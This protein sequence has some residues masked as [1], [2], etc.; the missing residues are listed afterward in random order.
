MDR[1]AI[2]R[3]WLAG[4][5]VW[6]LCAQVCGG[7]Q[8]IPYEDL[9]ARLTDLERLAGLPAAGEKCVQFSSYDRRSRYDP[10]TKKYVDWPANDDGSGFLNYE[11]RRMVMAYVEGPGCIWRIW[12][13]KPQAGRV[14]VYL[15]DSNTPAVNLPFVSYFGSGAAPF[16]RPSLGYVSAKGHNCYVPIPFARSCKVVAEEDWGRYYHFVIG[17]FPKAAQ[18]ETFRLP[19]RAGAAAA[20]AKADAFLAKGCGTDPAGTRQG[21][22]T[23][24]GRIAVGPGKAATVLALAGPRAITAL[25]VQTD[26]NDRYDLEDVLRELVL[27]IT[28]DGEK[29]PAVW[30]PLG[31]FFGTAPGQNLYRSVPMGMTEDGYYSLWYMPFARSAKVELVNDGTKA[32]EVVLRITHAPL[33]RPAEA[34]ARFHAKWHRDAF[35]P[36]RPDRWPDWTML[37]TAGRGRLVGLMLHVWNPRGGRCPLAREGSYWWGEGDMKFFVDGEEFPSSFGTGSDDYF[38]FAWTCPDLFEHAYHCQTVN[39][40]NQGHVSLNRWHVSDD[41]PFQKGFEA[42]I[43]KYFPN[44]WPTRYAAVAYWY[45]APGGKD[46]YPAVPVKER[47]GWYVQPQDVSGEAEKAPGAV[48]FF[49]PLRGSPRGTAPPGPS[50]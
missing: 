46:A 4:I 44:D 50:F 45:L 20:L 29:A 18:V 40:N 9:A 17:R 31:D 39:H 23:E 12:S 5:G 1:G 30:C 33:R 37:T 27:R 19:L 36:T 48:D 42:A 35:V 6:V 22:K 24:G 43:E 7:Q 25:R 10:M 2:V 41:V 8:K 11:G 13:A 34:F 38:G 49:P 15:D 16:D 47:L 28:W 21:E 3:T 26:P 14:A 32:R